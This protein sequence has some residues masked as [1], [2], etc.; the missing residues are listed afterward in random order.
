MGF[1]Q[2][3]LSKGDR[4]RFVDPVV[5]MGIF[6]IRHICSKSEIAFSTVIGPLVVPY[7]RLHGFAQLKYL[8]VI[9]SLAE[10]AK[11]CRL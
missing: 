7:R 1:E 5:E 9:C 11:L 3:K 10:T 8:C 6:G 2:E 4:A